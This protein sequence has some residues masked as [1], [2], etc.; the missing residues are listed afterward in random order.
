MKLFNTGPQGI[1]G[2]KGD[3]GDKGDPGALSSYT[4]TAGEALGGHRVTVIDNNLAYYADSSNLSHI[5]KPLG[6]S[7]NASA[8]GEEINIV[9]FGEM[10]ESS[11][12]WDINKPIWIGLNGLLTQIVPV[13][14]F[15]CII[16]KPITATK[17]FVKK[18]NIT[19]LGG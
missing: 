17:I 4:Y 13:S 11:W 18:E 16:A 19:I 15:S 2:D 9:F 3:K 10:E 12:N 7:S 8:E 14:G 5:N 1:Q 6:I